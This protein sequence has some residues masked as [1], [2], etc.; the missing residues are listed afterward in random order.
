M[1]LSGN[2]QSG[3]GAVR[4]RPPLAFGIVA[5]LLLILLLLA[6]L[7]WDAR[8][9][10]LLQEEIDAIRA[11]GEPLRW[12]EVVSPPVPDEEN[13]AL[14][15]RE[16]FAIL[17]DAEGASGSIRPF[18]SDPTG[19]VE[20]SGEE[21]LEYLAR[22]QGALI[23]LRRA[24]GL[25][26]CRFPRDESKPWA[27]TGLP[28]M[29][30]S[31]ARNALSLDAFS[32]LEEGQVH[33]ATDDVEAML[34]L[35][36]AILCEPTMLSFLI[37]S[38]IG[39]EATGVAASA[40]NDPEIDATSCRRLSGL[41]SEWND[42]AVLERCLIGERAFGLRAWAAFLPEAETRE[43]RLA[44]S[45]SLAE[46]R[47]RRPILRTEVTYYLRMMSRLIEI[48]RLPYQDAEKEIASIRADLDDLPFY[49]T[50]ARL[51]IPNLLEVFRSAGPRARVETVAIAARLKADWLEGTE[52]P[53]TPDGIA[54]DPYSGKPYVYRREG[55]GF[56]IY[57]VGPDGNDDGGD[58]GPWNKPGKDL[59][60]RVP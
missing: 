49:V 19:L 21:V 51:A 18:G 33:R 35:S 14:I 31:R 45:V 47:G 13:A 30:I 15:Y 53:E 40:L 11:A 20:D 39:L 54:I 55:E 28:F 8:A 44:D 41:F 27:A 4:K 57:S 56:L 60:W 32:A 29:K 38:S 1:S 59:G 2:L 36:D 23:L 17:R 25:P 42:R 48:S 7:A 34:G 58:I 5:F 6:Y 3:F 24:A 46:T 12:S 10:R 26:S 9:G 37:R 52:Y 22:I 16:A 50:S 43:E